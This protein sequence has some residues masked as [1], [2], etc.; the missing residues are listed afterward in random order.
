MTHNFRLVATLRPEFSDW[1]LWR[2]RALVVTF[3]CA[4]GSGIPQ[5]MAAIDAAVDATHREPFASMKLTL[6]KI[7]LTARGL[8]AGLLLGREGPSVQV[9]AGS[10]HDARRCLTKRSAVT[11]R[12]LLV[13]GGAAGIAAALNTPLTGVM[14]AIEE[15]PRR[16]E[17]RGSADRFSGP[18]ECRCRFAMRCSTCVQL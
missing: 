14:F 3:S 16:P 17:Q 11:E 8:L 2:V 13:A 18:Q 4:E 7:V 6:A 12:G 1:R 10:R 15:L 9:A 5:V